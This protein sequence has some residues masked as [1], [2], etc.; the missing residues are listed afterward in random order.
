MERRTLGQAGSQELEA[1]RVRWDDFL[2][3][4]LSPGRAATWGDVPPP[5]KGTGTAHTLPERVAG[6]GAGPGGLSGQRCGL[7]LRLWPRR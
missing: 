4:G 7:S 3:A 6:K 2:L 1:K 5:R